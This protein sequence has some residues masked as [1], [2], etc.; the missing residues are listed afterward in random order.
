MEFRPII[1]KKYGV[2]VDNKDVFFDGTL[3]GTLV[4]IVNL[5]KPF[6]RL[7]I[8]QIKDELDSRRDEER[9]VA[10]LCNGSELEIQAELEGKTGDALLTKS[11]CAISSMKVSIA[12]PLRKQKLISRE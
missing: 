1:V 11:S 7:D 6:T 10:V 8:H 2:E 4:K 12:K 9:D 3:E 5:T